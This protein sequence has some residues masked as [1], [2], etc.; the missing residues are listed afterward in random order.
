[1]PVHLLL[2]KNSLMKVIDRILTLAKSKKDDSDVSS[3]M[4]NE[5]LSKTMLS[6]DCGVYVLM[7]QMQD[8]EG[9]T[10]NQ[11]TRRK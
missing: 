1:M 5:N 7:D 9:R 4:E 3:R 8:A 6:L 10:I 2:T 11:T